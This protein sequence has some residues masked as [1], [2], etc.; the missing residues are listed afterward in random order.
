MNPHEDRLADLQMQ[1]AERFIDIWVNEDIRPTG[2]VRMVTPDG[3]MTLRSHGTGGEYAESA[4]DKA[5][6]SKAPEVNVIVDNGVSTES[7]AP[8][9]EASPKAS[10]DADKPAPE[11][12]Q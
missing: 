3:E 12:S 6:A 8:T 11:E 7:S 9:T 5:S 1:L 10:A 2:I 4:I